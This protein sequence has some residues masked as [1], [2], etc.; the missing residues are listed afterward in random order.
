MNFSTVHPLLAV[1]ARLETELTTLADGDLPYAITAE[2]WADAGA[3]ITDDALTWANGQR[4]DH[5]EIGV[6]TRHARPLSWLFFTLGEQC[7][8]IIHVGNRHGFYGRLADAA[9]GHLAAHQ[10]ESADWRPLAAAVIREAAA[11]IEEN[12]RAPQSRRRRGRT[13]EVP[14]VLDLAFA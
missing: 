6:L 1:L 12:Q 11:F 7:G 14:M 13:V 5:A 4:T 9:N 10:P 2:P 3:F 8:R